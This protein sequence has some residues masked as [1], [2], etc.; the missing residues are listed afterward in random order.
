MEL[1]HIKWALSE[2]WMSRNPSYKICDQII[3]Y[4]HN[5]YEQVNEFTL[6][7]QHYF[8]PF[9]NPQHFTLTVLLKPSPYTFFSTQFKY[10]LCNQR[11]I[12]MCSIQWG[13]SLRFFFH[14]LRFHLQIKMCHF[15]LSYFLISSSSCPS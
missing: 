12:T 10:T 13:S 8:V 1:L 15:V 3:V 4:C 14:K 5:A 9:Y 11:I 6:W 2:L 7:G